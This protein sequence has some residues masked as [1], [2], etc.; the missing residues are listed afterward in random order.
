MYTEL[1]YYAIQNGRFKRALKIW[2]GLLIYVV[3]FMFINTFNPKGAF[4]CGVVPVVT[5]TFLF[6]QGNFGQHQFV[7]PK[8]CRSSYGL[9]FNIINSWLNVVNWN[10]GYHL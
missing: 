10:D 2:L 1:P 3:F 6:M 9:S 5:A 4:W 7:N 8:N